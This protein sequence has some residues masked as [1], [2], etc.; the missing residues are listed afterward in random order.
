MTWESDAVYGRI[1]QTHE[2]EKM[3]IHSRICKI[4]ERMEVK[5]KKEKQFD[6]VI[7]D[8]GNVLLTYDW[9]TYLSRFGFSGDVYEKVA[10]AIFRSPT[11]QLGDAG[12]FDQNEWLE[13]FVRNEPSCESEIRTVY[14]TIGDCLQVASYA[15]ALI[16]HFKEQGCSI[17]YLSNYSE[18]LRSKTEH[19]LSVLDEFDGGVFSYEERCV[20]PDA[21]IYQ[22][23]IDR[24]GITPEKAMFFD[25]L[26]ANIEAAKQAG[27]HGVVFTEDVAKDIL[28]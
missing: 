4:G 6:T 14:E 21:K 25:D 13:Q 9:E 24:Y 27:I 19:L 12:V 16:R 2:N 23:L 10:D 17:Y 15:P 18:G 3:H 7:F 1:E 5:N 20:K 22:I 8:I 11:W 28:K 26:E